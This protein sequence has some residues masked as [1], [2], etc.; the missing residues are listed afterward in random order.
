P[1]VAVERVEPLIQGRRLEERPVEIAR[2][3]DDR[4]LEQA[5]IEGA[6][7]AATRGPGGGDGAKSHRA[8]ASAEIDQVG[9][10]GARG[11]AGADRVLVASRAAE[12]ALVEE[13]HRL[14]RAGCARA[15]DDMKRLV[16]D[17]PAAVEGDPRHGPAPGV[18]REDVRM[19]GEHDVHPG[20]VERE[21]ARAPEGASR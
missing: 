8:A 1:L 5:W 6:E 13:R 15:G 4:L 21:I 16:E 17:H 20:A 2:E 3:L 7:E 10:R 9:R 19:A 12:G 14:E 11:E 18:V